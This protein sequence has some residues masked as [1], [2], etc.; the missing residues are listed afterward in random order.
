M[1]ISFSKLVLNEGQN[2]G[3]NMAAGIGL[4]NETIECIDGGC[5]QTLDLECKKFDVMEPGYGACTKIV[6]LSENQT[7][8][9]DNG[10]CIEGRCNQGLECKVDG[11]PGFGTCTKSVFL[12]ETEDCGCDS[13][14]CIFGWCNQGLECQTD[15]PGFGTC[16]KT[17]GNNYYEHGQWFIGIKYIGLCIIKKVYTG[18]LL[19]PSSFNMVCSLLR[20]ILSHQILSP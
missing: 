3:C 5:D 7:C 8:G 17:A 14:A 6:F 13:G 4:A 18:Q 12:N 1:N 20:R 16:E 11:G 9:C 19:F 2:C 15:G 10:T